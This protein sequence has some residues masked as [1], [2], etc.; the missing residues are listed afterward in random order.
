MNLIIKVELMDNKELKKTIEA[1]KEIEKEYSV[2][3]TLEVNWR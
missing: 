2:T 3:C 1:V